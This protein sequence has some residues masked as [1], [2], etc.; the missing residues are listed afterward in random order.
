[1]GVR[2]RSGEGVLQRNG[3]P[4][5]CFWRV[6]FFS[7]PLRLSDVL[8]ANLEGPEK[9]R[10]LQK[11]P[12]GQPF[13]KSTKVSHKR[14]FALLT[15]NP[16]NLPEK[17]WQYTSNL[18]HNMPPI[19]NAVPCWLLSLEERQ[20]P[21]YTSSF[22]CSTPPICTA[23]RLPFVTTMLLR[24]YQWLG[25]QDFPEVLVPEVILRSP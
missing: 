6:R 17:Y 15:P 22:Y 13:W 3:C 24:K 19:C 5:G 23:I 9:K 8:R 21:Q 18:Y 7:A 25:V 12:F 20:T 10:T 11:H 4:K 16:Y 1:M 2:Q 14:A